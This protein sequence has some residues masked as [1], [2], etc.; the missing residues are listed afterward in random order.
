MTTTPAV[1][2]FLALPH[3]QHEEFRKGNVD[4]GF[5]VKHAADLQ[6]PPPPT[7]IRTYLS[8]A[9]KARKGKAKSA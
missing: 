4:T 6:T 9:I 1:T 2:L 3:L 8:D 5:I 7:K